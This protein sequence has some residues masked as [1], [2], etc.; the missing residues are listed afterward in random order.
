MERIL[1]A[2]NIWKSFQKDGKNKIEVLKG[3][4]LEVFRG[5]F[6]CLYGTLGSWQNHF[7]PHFGNAG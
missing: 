1:E 3:V 2:K 6:F 5:E 4:S 7:A